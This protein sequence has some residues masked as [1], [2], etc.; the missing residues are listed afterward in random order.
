M[1]QPAMVDYLQG[2]ALRCCEHTAPR[3]D[4]RSTRM[5]RFCMHSRRR[6]C[7]IWFTLNITSII[8]CLSLQN[9]PYNILYIIIYIYVYI[10]KS[11]YQIYDHSMITLVNMLLISFHVFSSVFELWTCRPCQFTRIE[12]DLVTWSSSISAAGTVRRNVLFRY[13]KLFFRKLDMCFL[14]KVVSKVSKQFV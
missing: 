7:S 10:F 6:Q 4:L 9:L 1:F 13:P 5:R 14:T 8:Q 12:A 2:F 3:N 11:R